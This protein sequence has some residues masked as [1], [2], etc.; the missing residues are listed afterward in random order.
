MN[1]VKKI[2][3]ILLATSIMIPAVF[4]EG[5]LEKVM[6]AIASTL[7]DMPASDIEPVVAPVVSGMASII[8]SV[9]KCCTDASTFVHNN[10]YVV[11]T[12]AGLAVAGYVYNK[13]KNVRTA[14]N[15]IGRNVVR[16]V[17]ATYNGAT[18]LISKF[19]GAAGL[20]LPGLG[21][22]A[23]A[24]EKCLKAA[25]SAQTYVAAGVENAQSII[26]KIPA[27]KVGVTTAINSG[28]DNA[29]SIGHLAFDF[30]KNSGTTMREHPYITTAVVVGL[31]VIGYDIYKYDPKAE[32]DRAS[33][34]NKMVAK[35]NSVSD[36]Q[37]TG[38]HNEFWGSKALGLSIITQ[39]RA[40][41]QL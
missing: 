28:V 9:Q 34:G 2:V 16:G 10:K 3:A 38:E 23:V 4:A 39:A 17:R 6:P 35:N 29:K 41:N 37:L 31:G 24:P 7:A 32:S 30:V 33:K 26:A 11:G 13:S 27:F 36:K 18:T 22:Y 25:Q 14:T 21:A 5:E 20:V 1:Y 12:I 15:F 8:D 19:P 40:Q